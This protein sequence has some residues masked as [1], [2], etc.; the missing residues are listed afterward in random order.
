MIIDTSNATTT[1]VFSQLTLGNNIAVGTEGNS[2][3]LIKTYARTGYCV[4]MRARGDLSTDQQLYIPNKSGDI[5]IAQEYKR[6]TNVTPSNDYPTL[7]SY[8]NDYIYPVIGNQVYSFP[9]S[10]FP[11]LPVTNW[12]FDVT[13]H[14]AGTIFVTIHKQLSN[15][16]D[17]IREIGSNNQWITGWSKIIN[18]YPANTNIATFGY[19]QKFGSLTFF[20]FTPLDNADLYNIS[21]N[22]Q[23]QMG[24]DRTASFTTDYFRFEVVKNGFWCYSDN[25]DVNY[26]FSNDYY[27]LNFI[28]S[29][30]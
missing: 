19:V 12:G 5:A 15:N 9:C 3:G 29:P 23:S 8:I 21:C 22:G 13:V 26:W 7:L 28:V 25:G 1:E 2:T 20:P 18:L 16:E 27:R 4:E 11:D 6:Q 30:K 17:Y 24:T 14:I 10:G